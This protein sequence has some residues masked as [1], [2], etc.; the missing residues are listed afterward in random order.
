MSASAT[1][2]YDQKNKHNE[3]TKHQTPP[4]KKRKRKQNGFEEVKLK[5][6]E[7]IKVEPL[8]TVSILRHIMKFL[9]SSA[10]RVATSSF[11]HSSWRDTIYNNC[12]KQWKDK[13]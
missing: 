3:I 11:V 9:L 10:K 4:N 5:P 13:W 6:T 1:G 7:E 12:L 2:E 8:K